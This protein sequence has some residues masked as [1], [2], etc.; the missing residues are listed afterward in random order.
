MRCNKLTAE[1]YGNVNAVWY[2]GGAVSLPPSGM[3]TS[4]TWCGKLTAVRYGG[5]A[6]SLPPCGMVAVR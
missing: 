3:V 6:V 4:M 2:G 5:G 1:R